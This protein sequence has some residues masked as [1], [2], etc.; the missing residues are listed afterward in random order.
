MLVALTLTRGA[1]RHYGLKVPGGLGLESLTNRGKI[2]VYL[3]L[4]RH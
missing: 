3:K 1:A 2:L 4:Y